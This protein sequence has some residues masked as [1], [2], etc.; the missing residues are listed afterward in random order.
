MAR[1]F[2]RIDTKA[3]WAALPPEKQLEVGEAAVA[4]IAAGYVQ[5]NVKQNDHLGVR[6]AE[7]AF[8]KLESE[9][10]DVFGKDGAAFM[11]A[12]GRHKVPAGLGMI[13]KAC[14]CTEED[15]CPGGCGWEGE[16]LCTACAGNGR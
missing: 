15:A 4:F 9:L 6:V 1:I 7:A 5:F 2:E 13:C 3:F 12:R 11:G 8:T 16:N 14:G 10:F